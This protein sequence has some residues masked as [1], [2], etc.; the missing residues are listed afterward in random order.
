MTDKE[1]WDWF[2]SKKTE[3]EEFIIAETDD[4]SIYDELTDKL[5]SYSSYVIPELTKDSDDNN[6]LIL[7]CDG[8]SDGIPFVERLYESAPTIDKWKIQKFR[9]PGQ[10][11]E[12]NYDG[13]K[14]K[15]DDI[16]AK[17]TFDG[18]YYDIEL[19]IKGYD[20]TDKRYKG[21]AFLY[22]DHL[23]GEY[24][25]MTKI[26]HIEFKKLGLSNNGDEVTLQELKVIVER[27]N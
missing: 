20:D 8:I 22:L 18:Q 10:V 23:V 27:L 11:R 25:V 19:F 5:N 17:Y 1:F 21:L 2:K 6:V 24:N 9:V 7:S 3:I 15:A 13:L 16:K 12:L 14:F 4:Y 26:G